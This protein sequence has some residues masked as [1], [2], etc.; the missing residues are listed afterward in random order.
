M[1]TVFWIGD[2][3]AICLRRDWGLIGKIGRNS[4]I[5]SAFA[6]LRRQDSP[7]GCWWVEVKTRRVHDLDQV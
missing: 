7:L 6:P 3:S 5:Q 2:F 4:S 1:F